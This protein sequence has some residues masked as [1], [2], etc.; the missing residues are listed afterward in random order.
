MDENVLLSIIS[1]LLS[2]LIGVV[3]GYLRTINEKLSDIRTT[4]A[5]IKVILLHKEA[6]QDE[7]KKG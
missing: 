3:L 2:I 6:R 4:L 1:I 7:D 5:E